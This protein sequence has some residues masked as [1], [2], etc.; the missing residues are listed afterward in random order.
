PRLGGG[1]ADEAM[2]TRRRPK[3]CSAPRIQLACRRARLEVISSEEDTVCSPSQVDGKSATKSGS[4]SKPR[5]RRGTDE[6]GLLLPNPSSSSSSSGD[7][8]EEDCDEGKGRAPRFQLAT[9]RSSLLKE[10]TGGDSGTDKDGEEGAEE[11]GK[12][13]EEEEEEEEQG[14]EDEE[15]DE[16][17]QEKE[18]EETG[19]KEEEQEDEK[20]QERDEEEEE[21]EKEQEDEER[22]EEREEE[23]I[24]EKEKEEGTSTEDDRVKREATTA[25]SVQNLLI[26]VPARQRSRVLENIVTYYSKGSH[27]VVITGSKAECDELADG[28]TFKTL[29]SQVL[30]EDDREQTIKGFLTKGVKAL[31][32]THVDAR[33]IDMSDIDLV[34]HYRPPRDADC[35]AHRSGRM[36]KA[37]RPGVTVTLCAENEM[38]DIR[39]I[40]QRVGFR[41]ECRAVPSEEQMMTLAVMLA[42]QQIKGVGDDRA[43][44]FRGAAQELLAEDKSADTELLLAKCL[45]TIARMADRKTDVTAS[46]DEADTEEVGTEQ[47][48]SD[49]AEAD[50]EQHKKEQCPIPGGSAESVLQ[51]DTL[52][53]DSLNDW[54]YLTPDD[55]VSISTSDAHQSSAASPSQPASNQAASTATPVVVRAVPERAVRAAEASTAAIRSKG[56]GTG[57]AGGGTRGSGGGRRRRVFEEEDDDDDSDCVA[58]DAVKGHDSAKM[59]L[60]LSGEGDRVGVPENI[61]TGPL[62]VQ[63]VQEGQAASSAPAAAAQGVSETAVKAAKASAEAV[64]AKN[65]ASGAPGGTP[66]SGGGKRRRVCEDEDEDDDDDSDC[67]IA[68][69]DKGPE[70]TKLGLGLSEGGGIDGVLEDVS[71]LED[72]VAGGAAAV[73]GGTSREVQ[74]YGETQEGGEDEEGEALWNEDSD[75]VVDVAPA[76]SKGKGKGKGKARD[77]ARGADDDN[78]NRNGTYSTRSDDCESV[79]AAAAAAAATASKTSSKSRGGASG[80]RGRRRPR[81]AAAS[82]GINYAAIHEGL[83]LEDLESDDGGSVE[84]TGKKRPRRTKSGSQSKPK[85]RRGTDELG[86]LQPNRSSSSSS[87][88][89]E[90]EVF[91][92][93]GDDVA[94]PPTNGAP[95]AKGRAAGR[96]VPTR[97]RRGATP[98]GESPSP[99]RSLENTDDGSGADT[100]GEEEEED[101]ED[102]SMPDRRRRKGGR[103]RR[104]VLAEEDE[105][106]EEEEEAEESE[107]EENP[108]ALLFQQ[109]QEDDPDVEEAVVATSRAALTE[110]EHENFMWYT[111]LEFLAKAVQG[112]GKGAA[113]MEKFDSMRH[114]FTDYRKAIKNFEGRVCT[115]RESVAAGGS[116]NQEFMTAVTSYPFVGFHFGVSHEGPTEIDDEEEGQ[117]IDCESLGRPDPCAACHRRQRE[118]MST[119]YLAG[120]RGGY[121]SKQLWT[122][123]RWDRLLPKGWKSAPATSANRE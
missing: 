87:S 58:V 70:S 115:I 9:R 65:N 102:E 13:Q 20:E 77:M 91:G 15:V 21:E 104:R 12:D 86:R 119:M 72:I 6:I 53:E 23:E 51:A 37:G 31:V 75:E 27:A 48:D 118:N 25:N 84:V 112:G 79:T 109:M 108:G 93:D 66:G 96:Q 5:R 101:E 42:R 50:A 32:V 94:I 107:V 22:D 36:E 55:E 19:E 56:K 123:A 68:D 14:K 113:F 67:I 110:E 26:E 121:K 57:G 80:S 41:F 11:D 120:S 38:C 122:S 63:Q 90:E 7:E 28:R 1:Q 10:D 111:Y 89:S 92:E 71:T 39:N 44:F 59:G 4:K 99:L 100:G 88:S 18:D 24:E 61:V 43:E 3:T 64:A 46:D 8:E 16:K 98:P 47:D 117:D 69:A 40:E 95:T 62:Q 45:A 34:V 106:E 97:S 103:K 35:Y 82:T 73:V 116:W 52:G 29:T 49:A 60:D 54:Q 74:H 33:G 85:R 17:V 2:A 30:S 76:I 83:P 105:E 114:A 81:R 78:E